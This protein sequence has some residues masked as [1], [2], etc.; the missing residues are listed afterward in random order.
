MHGGAFNGNGCRTLTKN[1]DALQAL[2]PIVAQPFTETFRALDKVVASCFG[3]NIDSSFMDYI[4]RFKSMYMDLVIVELGYVNVT[5][6]M[7][8]IF[9]HVPGF[10]G[11]Y[12]GLGC[13]SEQASES[14]HADFKKTLV[15][16]KVGNPHDSYDQHL[17]RVVMDY[18]CGQWTLVI[19]FNMI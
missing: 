19:I 10:C 13:H 8:C 11:K 17:P 7:H 9:H 5:P 3:N 2:A 15:R 12:G 1:V 16:Y 14:V 4:L 6:K 18:N